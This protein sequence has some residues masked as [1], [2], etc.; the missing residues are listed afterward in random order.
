[1]HINIKFYL[2]LQTQVVE[3]YK[4]LLFMISTKNL[5][6]DYEPPPSYN[7]LDRDH[8]GSL[9]NSEALFH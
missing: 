5:P 4:I 6:E 9:L 2:L 7:M 8:D 1:M 3:N